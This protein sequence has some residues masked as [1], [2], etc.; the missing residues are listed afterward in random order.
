M[1]MP[2]AGSVLGRSVPGQQ[3]AQSLRNFGAQVAALPNAPGPARPIESAAP[4]RLA[5]ALV[6][7]D[8]PKQGRPVTTMRAPVTKLPAGKS[9]I[10]RTPHA[11]QTHMAPAHGLPGPEHTIRL[12]GKTSSRA[13]HLMA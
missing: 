4:P 12:R 3:A 9:T 11:P 5:P 7:T 6:K 1:A 13:T 8:P 2:V 10:V